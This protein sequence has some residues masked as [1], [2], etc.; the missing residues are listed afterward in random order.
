MTG[1]K[2]AELLPLPAAWLHVLVALSGGELHGYAIMSE[3]ERLTDGVVTMGPG[4]LYGTLK[5]L[6]SQGLVEESEGPAEAESEGPARRYYRLT[7][8]GER[9]L[10]AE[11]ARLSNLI[12]AASR[13]AVPSEGT[14]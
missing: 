9:V 2:P 6:H 12:H 8:F 4:T 14:S 7:G 11:T 1:R 10:A 13:G 5:R 3:V